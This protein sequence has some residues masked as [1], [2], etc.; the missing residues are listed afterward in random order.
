MSCVPRPKYCIFCGS[1]STGASYEIYENPKNGNPAKA[2]L[3]HYE[4]LTCGR[5]WEPKEKVV[6]T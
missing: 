4:C 1:T 6:F 2:R 5:K 3:L